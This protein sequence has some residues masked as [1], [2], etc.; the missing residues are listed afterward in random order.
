ME[1]SFRHA[2]NASK[3][4]QNHSVK[5]VDEEEGIVEG[6]GPSQGLRNSGVNLRPPG[7]HA[8]GQGGKQMKIKAGSNQVPNTTGDTIFK[9]QANST[10]SNH[11]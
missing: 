6:H 4:T 11:G 7:L 2:N 8:P 10:T 1:S 5:V 3:Q 9:Q